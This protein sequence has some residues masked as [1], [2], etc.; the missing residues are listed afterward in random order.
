MSVDPIIIGIKLT[1]YSLDLLEN[2]ATVGKKSDEKIDEIL[3]FSLGSHYCT[4]ILSVLS[5]L[6]FHLYIVFPFHELAT[7]IH[8]NRLYLSLDFIVV[9]FHWHTNCYFSST[10]VSCGCP[11]VNI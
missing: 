3:S 2:R 5:L 11:Q 6:Y 7:I 10:Q 4:R 1:K 9:V 8:V